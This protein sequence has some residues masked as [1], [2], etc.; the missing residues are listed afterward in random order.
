MGKKVLLIYPQGSLEVFSRSK[1]KVA[2]TDVG[3]A[4]ELVV[5]G[6]NGL[7][8]PAGD[9][10]A[11]VGSINK[12]ITDP[13]FR[14]KFKKTGLVAVNRLPNKGQYLSDYKKSWEALI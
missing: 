9:R 10:A 6:E 2:M 3:C 13:L 7:V 11:L 12:L 1:I 4:G 14:E 5:N 8:T